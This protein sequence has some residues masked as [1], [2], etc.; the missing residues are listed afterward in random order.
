MGPFRVFASWEGDAR[1][2]IAHPTSLTNHQT[3]VTFDQVHGCYR[4]DVQ[5]YTA[6]HPMD[7]IEI[8]SR[9][10]SRIDI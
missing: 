2:T 3:P 9:V 5:L 8:V 4:I 6:D 7:I 10:M 1:G